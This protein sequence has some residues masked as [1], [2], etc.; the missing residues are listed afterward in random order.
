MHEV[1]FWRPDPQDPASIRARSG[2]STDRAAGCVVV[3]R[4]DRYAA[5]VLPLDARDELAGFLDGVLLLA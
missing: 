3:V 1:A 2:S 4:P 5:H